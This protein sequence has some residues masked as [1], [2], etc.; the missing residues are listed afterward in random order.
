MAAA[1]TNGRIEM[2]SLEDLRF[3]PENPR[4]P[5][6]VDGENAREVISWM[7]E[8]A[9]L[10]ELM[11]SIG[12]QGFFEG[13]PLLAV[14]LP[15]GRYRVVEGNRRL[16]A[17][18]LLSRPSLA[19]PRRRRGAQAAADEAEF[20]PTE[21]PLMLFPDRASIMDYLGYRHVTGVKEWDTLAKARYVQQ[22]AARSNGTRVTPEVRREIARR[23]GSRPDYVGRLL[24]AYALFERAEERDYYGLDISDQLT[25]D[26]S[27]LTTALSYSS[28]ADYVGLAE[29]AD[30]RLRNVKDRRYSELLDW[31]FTPTESGRS[32]VGESR[33]LR[34]LA[35]IVRNDVAVGALRRGRNISDAALLTEAPLQLFETT[36]ASARD[37]LVLAQSQFHRVDAP[38]EDDADILNEVVR[39]A[40]DL[41]KRVR[42]RLDELDDDV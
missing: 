35:L 12:A 14:P 3:D 22:L 37:K 19:P 21:L 30:T 28:I 39:A 36:I 24:S 16:A 34:E 1:A 4:L 33:N 25:A 13:E 41:Y 6:R 17:V 8:D 9:S 38:A 18:Q 40:R 20:I 11:G 31:L 5:R 7:L 23:I 10:I 42:D 32:V 29:P 15:R 26:F 27:L 2:V